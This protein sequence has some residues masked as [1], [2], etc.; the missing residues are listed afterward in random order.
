MPGL[1][2]AASDKPLFTV[3]QSVVGSVVDIVYV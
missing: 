2:P 1:N 3:V